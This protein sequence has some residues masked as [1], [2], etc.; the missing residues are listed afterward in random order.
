MSIL[1]FLRPRFHS[2]KAIKERPKGELGSGKLYFTQ[3]VPTLFAPL[4]TPIRVPKNKKTKKE[5]AI[6]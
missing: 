3:S 4:D 6:D 2:F 5:A 1:C